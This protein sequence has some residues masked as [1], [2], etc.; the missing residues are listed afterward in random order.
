MRP[1]I[2]GWTAIGIVAL[3]FAMAWEFGPR[4]LNAVVTPLLVVLVVGALT[5]ARATRPEVRRAPVAAGF[6]DD[7]RTVEIGL[8]TASAVSAT[9]RDAVG[10]GAAVTDVES[11]SGAETEIDGSGAPA[12]TTTLEGD[13]RFEY[14]V[15]LERR[16]DHRLGPLTITVTDVFGLF[17]RR[18]DDAE[19]TSVLVYPR[20]HDL[21][22]GP[23]S[24]LR[25]F[26]ERERGDRE[27]F[28]HLREYQR[29]DS[30]RDVHWKSAAKRPDSDLVVTEYAA[31]E[32]TGS[33]TIAAEC[34]PGRDDDLA[35]AV[36][37]VATYLLE[38]DVGVG[39]TVPNG[40]YPPGSGPDHRH[41]L[42][43][44]FA[45]LEAGDLEDEQRRAADIVV[46]ADGDG[47][48]VVVDGRSIPFD[49]LVET[50]RGNR[51]SQRPS[52]IG[53]ATR[54]RADGDESG[55]AS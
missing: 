26:V 30:L 48:T 55:V 53:Q 3:S 42:L 8:E 54:E 45:V 47:T 43:A 12:A 24:D 44:A 33:V 10:E 21:R 40:E 52:P 38:A 22:S 2:R 15:R 19:T 17:K 16:G 20:V 51:Q 1:T 37:S 28:D 5:T 35:T 6:V 46:R 29:G 34:A 23:G 39:V 4:A 25:A 9:V 36:A 32:E 18:F 11:V 7:R 50:R 49:R 14:A 27:E 13:D 31:D 41:T